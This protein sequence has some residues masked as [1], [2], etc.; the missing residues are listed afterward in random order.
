MRTVV[1]MKKGREGRGEEE[2]EEKGEEWGGRREGEEQLTP[3]CRV[4]L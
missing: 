1:K 2:E 4:L 3:G